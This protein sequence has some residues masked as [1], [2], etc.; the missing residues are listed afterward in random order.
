[1]VSLIIKDIIA[2]LIAFFT[3]ILIT[4]YIQKK[5]IEIGFVDKPNQ[6]KIHSY[7]IP[8]TGGIGLF[9]AFFIAQFVIRGISREFIGFFFASSLVL[10]IG[11]VDDYYKSKG[12]D[13]GALPKFAIQI[14]ACSIVFI[15]GIQIEGITNPITHKFIHFPVWFQ[16]FAT[17]IWIF[18]ITTVIN[19][20]DG[21]DGLA[22]GIT[23][24]SGVTL[25]FVALMNLTIISSAGISTY[26]AAALVGVSSAFLIFNRHP[27]KIFMGDSGATFLGF[28]LGTIAVEG[29]FKVATVVSLI[30][31]IL[32][33]GLPIF[34][35]LF[36]VFKRLKDGKSI[37][38]ADKSQVHFR[39]LD[40]GLNQKQAVL[41]LYLVSICFSL[42]SL[43]IMLL[44]KR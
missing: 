13:F 28:V 41:F 32:S 30:V 21:M 10:L 43:I 25:Y 35:N 19:F 24:I 39:L 20:M 16:Y 44:S 29:T 15:M 12:K 27:A 8:V 1:M 11:V 33:L 17:V 7:P 36:V 42:T 40:A 22:A 38:K 9:V 34:D 5:S 14:L 26:M 23:T 2:F 31:P 4:P 37:F 3:V 18:G 6:R